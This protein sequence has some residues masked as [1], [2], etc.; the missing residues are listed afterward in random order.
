MAFG[1]ITG[2]TL[3][4]V[5]KGVWKEPKDSWYLWLEIPFE[6]SKGLFNVGELADNRSAKKRLDFLKGLVDKLNHPERPTLGV[7]AGTSRNTITCDGQT[8]LSFTM[9][10][11]KEARDWLKADVVR[12]LNLAATE[13]STK[14]EEAPATEPATKVEEVPDTEPA[15]KVEEVPDTEPVPKAATVR[16]PKPSS[17][18][19]A[20]PSDRRSKPRTRKPATTGD[21]KKPK[22]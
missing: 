7:F 1:T 3:K 21:I 2:L 14:V 15:P 17:T 22:E 20:A 11:D 6:S 5:M 13:P 10:L 19:S 18:D 4:D 16:K 9:N 8:A 12:K